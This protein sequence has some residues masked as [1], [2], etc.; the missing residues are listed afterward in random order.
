MEQGKAA[1]SRYSFIDALYVFPGLIHNKSRYD[2]HE[3]GRQIIAYSMEREEVEPE[4]ASIYTLPRLTEDKL[5]QRVDVIPFNNELTKYREFVGWEPDQSALYRKRCQLYSKLNDETLLTTPKNETLKNP[6]IEKLLLHFYKEIATYLVC[7][8][9]LIRQQKQFNERLKT[10]VPYIKLE[11][12]PSYEVQILR[13]SPKTY[14]ITVL[15]NSKEDLDHRQELLETYIRFLNSVPTAKEIEEKQEELKPSSQSYMNKEDAKLIFELG[16]RIYSYMAQDK[17]G[18]K[19]PRW[20]FIT[21][22]T[23]LTKNMNAV[24]YN[25]FPIGRENLYLQGEDEKEPTQ[26]AM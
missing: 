24:L 6:S 11:E 13:N 8:R 14:P 16:K 10:V 17:P 26:K 3:M 19:T 5:R 15:P 25:I 21:I 18:T 2:A 22:K 1:L 20:N 23:M 7:E 9:H 12:K 4:Q